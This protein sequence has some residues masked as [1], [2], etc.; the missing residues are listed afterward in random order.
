M[1]I[2][3]AYKTT[4]IATTDAF[5]I[6]FAWLIAYLFRFDFDLL[7]KINMAHAIHILGISLVT[8]L[9]MF[10]A[11]KMHRIIWRYISIHEMLKIFYSVTCGF[12]L[13]N[14]VVYSAFGI[15][16]VPLSILPLHAFFY[17]FLVVGTRVIYRVHTISNIENNMDKNVVIIGA[18]SAAEGLLRDILRNKKRG[19]K[20]VGLLDNNRSLQGRSLHGVKV[21]GACN[22]LAHVID[23]YKVDLVFFAIPS[24]KDK[25]LFKF[26]YEVCEAQKTQV[27]RLPGLHHLT[28]GLVTVD[29]LKKVEIEDLLGRDQV[30]SLDIKL[31]QCLQNK[32][33]MVTGGGGSI[34]AELCRQIALNC[35][36][37]L[38][39]IDNCEFNLYSIHRELSN[40]FP[41][42]EIYMLLVDI[43]D[44]GEITECFRKIRPHIVFHAAAYKHVPMLEHQVFKAVKNNILG[45]RYLADLANECLV[46]RFILVSTD[47]AVNPTNVM[48]MTKR[49][50]EIYCQN[51]NSY[52]STNYTTVRFGNVLG[53]AGS[54]LPLFRQQLAA[55]GPLTV[56]HP[57][58]TRFFY[59][60]S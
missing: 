8:Y 36:H 59:D 42:L 46:G 51:K 56:T 49:L 27:R 52:A 3:K 47:K 37:K 60:D 26:V 35:P 38:C 19:F 16:Y 5:C 9:S 7:H 57:E 29:A 14:I 23:F 22:Q 6:L 50:A 48:G 30:I 20:P 11:F 40:A 24:I 54:V 34:G 21:L 32:I 44:L 43:S 55:G 13:T 28:D 1:I 31:S 41:L 15:H 17:L 18:G 12:V 58:M 2:N 53:S 39:I 4:I 25:Q 45:T 33:V 10:F